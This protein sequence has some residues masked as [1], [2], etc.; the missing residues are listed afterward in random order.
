MNYR[1]DKIAKKTWLI[2]EY[3]EQNSVYMYLLEGNSKAA[4]IDAGFGL[5]PLQS[6]VEELT[7]LPVIV[8]LTHGHFDHIGGVNA[9]SEVYMHP[10]DKNTFERH[11][12]KLRDIF[13]AGYVFTKINTKVLPVNDGDVV[14]LGGRSLQVIHVPGHSMGSICFL[15]RDNGRLYTGDT[16]CQANVLLQFD[17]SASVKT[18][19]ESLYKL[20]ELGSFYELTWP[21]HHS[22]PVGLQILKQ[23]LSA[24]EGILSG[25]LEGEPFPE[26]GVKVRILKYKDIGVVYCEDK[27]E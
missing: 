25:K 20:I 21:A 8:L 15:E 5:I 10:K 24:S 18:Y 27:I 26:Y 1:V 13:M 3:D 4:L 19:A 6:I 2:E 16:C 9:F 14:D 11:S 7:G 17:D 22:K 12:G 23:F